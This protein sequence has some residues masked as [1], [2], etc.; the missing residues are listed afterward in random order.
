MAEQEREA[1]SSSKKLI[2]PS[3]EGSLL[4]HQIDRP[5][6]RSPSR[7]RSL[8]QDTDDTIHR[9]S[10]SGSCSKVKA[11]S[12]HSD[13]DINLDLK[14]FMKTIAEKIKGLE[15]KIDGKTNREKRKRHRSP[16]SEDDPPQKKKTQSSKSKEVGEI[17]EEEEEEEKDINKNTGDMFE[18]LT[19]SEESE[20][21]EDS[22]SEGDEV[23]GDCLKG[24]EPL[25]EEIADSLAESVDNGIV[26][27]FKYSKLKEVCEKVKRPINCKNLIVPKT[28]EQILNI[29]SH[30]QEKRDRKLCFTQVLAVKA[31][32]KNVQ[33]LEKVRNAKKKKETLK[34]TEIEGDLKDIIKLSVAT[35]SALNQRRLENIAP[36]LPDE[37]KTLTKKPFMA[38]SD[39]NSAEFLFGTDLNQKMKEVSEEE[40]LKMK[41]KKSKN[42]KAPRTWKGGN[43]S[44]YKGQKKGFRKKKNYVPQEGKSQMP[45]A[46]RRINYQN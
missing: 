14:N 33:L 46:H 22:S 5:R 9:P 7:S 2:Q 19:D 12:H 34:P 40:K 43:K 6:S 23:F 13:E 20:N 41:I 31:M 24:V 38:N 27:E 1:Q 26:G 45:H 44:E 11:K 3:I 17:S 25:G 36:G 4:G 42:S 39:K 15:Q 28:N 21:E 29:L 35:L 16:D 30:P 10:G 18:G 37:Y 32:I 8:S